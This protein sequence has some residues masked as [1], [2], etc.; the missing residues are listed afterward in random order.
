MYTSVDNLAK[1]AVSED[2][3]PYFLCEYGHA[4]GLGPGSL[5]DYWDLIYANKRLAGGCIWEWVD[6]SV[7]TATE[8]GEPYYAYGGDF[9]DFPNDGNFCVD[10]LNYPDRTPHTGLIELKKVYEPVDFAYAAGELTIRNRYVFQGLD[11]LTR[12]EAHAR[13]RTHRAGPAGSERRR[14]PAAKRKL[15]AARLKG[16]GR[17]LPGNR[18]ERSL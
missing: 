1:E 10:A 3:R 2:T 17:I 8:D 5:K 14:A 16:H 9:G 11:H 13:R 4:M 6:H 18:C 7:L 12:L 15:P